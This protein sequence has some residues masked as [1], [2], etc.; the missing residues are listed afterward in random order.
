MR[1]TWP[2]S[3][4]KTPSWQVSD[5]ST[6][7][8][9]LT[10]ANGTFEQR[11]VLRPQ[12]GAHRPDREVRREQGREEHQLAREPDDRPHADHARTVVVPVQPGCRNRCCCRHGRH[13]VVSRSRRPPR[14]PYFRGH[15]VHTVLGSSLVVLLDASATLPRFTTGRLF[16]S[17]ELA[18]L[19]FVVT[20]WAAG[21]YLLGVVRLR[22]RGDR[23]PLGRTLS[24]VVVGMGSFY[25]RDRLR[26]G[27]LR[28]DA[29][30]R[31]HGAAHGA[32]HAGAA[33]PRAR[34][35]GHA[36]PAHAA[37]GAATL[38]A[39]GAALAGG[40]GALVPAAHAAAVRRV[41]VGAVLLRLVR[42]LPALGVRPRADARAPGAG[43]VP[44][45]LA[46]D[47]HRPGARGGWATRP[48]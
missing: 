15:I 4:A 41:A 19:P 48:G 1:P 12:V 29:A 24:F 6:R 22:R 30:E 5:D 27:R 16:T 25:R 43:R 42:R 35:A 7:I 33:G 47:G 13:Y 36:G 32:L 2:R 45:L 28:H 14:P 44:V 26:A 40:P 20:V 3:A 21:L 46:A 11:G 17:W 18:P 39:R 38:A 23:W 34:R 10:A 8:V 31:P 37:T 9:V